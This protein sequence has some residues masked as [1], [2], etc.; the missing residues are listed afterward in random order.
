MAKV[1]VSGNAFPQTL[2]GKKQGMNKEWAIVEGRGNNKTEADPSRKCLAHLQ[3]IQPHH[4]YVSPF[5]T[6]YN[7]IPMSG[8][9]LRFN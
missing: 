5:L 4:Q 9:V 6:S 1:L 2:K 7:L 8:R 3:V